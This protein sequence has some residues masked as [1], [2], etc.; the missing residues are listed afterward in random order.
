MSP[1]NFSANYSSLLCLKPGQ[2]QNSPGQAGSPRQS[3]PHFPQQKRSPQSVT[4]KGVLMAK[5]PVHGLRWSSGGK[6]CSRRGKGNF[7]VSR[8]GWGLF[9]INL[10]GAILF[11]G[12]DLQ[13]QGSIW[14]HCQKLFAVLLHLTKKEKKKLNKAGI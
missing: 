1:L 12:G 6:K 11:L 9:P 8:N 14:L 3:V 2:M 5:L 7:P 4:A 10:I 13:A